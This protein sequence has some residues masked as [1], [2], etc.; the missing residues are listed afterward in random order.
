LYW[1]RSFGSR[2]LTAV[3]EQQGGSHHLRRGDEGWEEVADVSV[4][5][6]AVV[7]TR[8]QAAVVL[9]AL[10]S[11]EAREAFHACDTEVMQID[12]KSVGPVV[13]CTHPKPRNTPQPPFSSGAHSARAQ[14]HGHLTCF[15]M[16]SGPDFDYGFGK[17]KALFVDCLDESRDLLPL[18]K[19]WFEDERY[20][21]VWHNYGFDRHIMFNEGI[22]CGGFAGDTMHM[23]RLE[24]SSR[25]KF[26]GGGGGYGLEAL[27]EDL[28]GRRKR[29]MKE[30][31]G[32]RKLKKDGTPGAIVELPPIEEMQRR[33]E[34]RENWIR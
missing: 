1:C 7:T 10:N 25:A 24:D 4:P 23:A 33:R 13:S 20:K 8:E 15:S 31:F 27:T 18:F 26:G 16:Y 21:K 12:L 14:G 29:P 17:G 11:R 30:I 32:K 3:A 5:E 6:V 22:D 19:G 9:E 2:N 28:L 34:Y